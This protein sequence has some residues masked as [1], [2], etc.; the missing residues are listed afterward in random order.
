MESQVG[1]CPATKS[2]DG[3]LLIPSSSSLFDDPGL[4]NRQL[5]GYLPALTGTRRAALTEVVNPISDFG[6]HPQLAPLWAI[7]PFGLRPRSSKQAWDS[8]LA[9]GRPSFLP[10]LG[11]QFLE[12]GGLWQTSSGSTKPFHETRTPVAH[13]NET[14]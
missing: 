4:Y 7:T 10:L 14:Y 11:S 12:S 9:T 3:G 5:S 2:A 8:A 13:K 6:P 1:F